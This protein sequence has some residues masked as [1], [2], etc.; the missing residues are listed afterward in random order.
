MSNS[1]P[2]TRQKND[3]SVKID[4][5]STFLL[6]LPGVKAGSQFWLKVQ[7]LSGKVLSLDKTKYLLLGKP[8][9]FSMVGDSGFESPPDQSGLLSPGN[10][11]H[12]E[13]HE[14]LMK[15]LEN[16]GCGAN[17]NGKRFVYLKLIF[18]RASL[19]ADQKVIIY[20]ETLKSLCDTLVE[21]FDSVI[22]NAYQRSN[23]VCGNC[24]IS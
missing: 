3:Q 10:T 19:D 4:K 8:A 16:A 2:D 24:E 14:S 17:D 5:R 22:G 11:G 1:N 6:S 20:P 7:P 18:V 9:L 13:I 23:V 15:L 21:T 12:R